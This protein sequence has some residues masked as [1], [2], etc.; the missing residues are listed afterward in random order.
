M[1]TYLPGMRE[2]ARCEVAIAEIS[3]LRKRKLI[4]QILLS[5]LSAG[6]RM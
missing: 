2:E 4:A 6:G 5:V 3:E 1:K